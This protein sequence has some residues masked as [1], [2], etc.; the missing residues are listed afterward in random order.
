MTFRLNVAEA[1]RNLT[2]FSSSQLDFKGLSPNAHIA[3]QVAPETRPLYTAYRVGYG[4]PALN[5][6]AL[7]RRAAAIAVTLKDRV[8]SSSTAVQLATF[9]D[10][11]SKQTP[12]LLS[13][14]ILGGAEEYVSNELP[15]AIGGVFA[16]EGGGHALITQDTR[17]M[18]PLDQVVPLNLAFAYEPLLQPGIMK[19]PLSQEWEEMRQN[20]QLWKDNACQAAKW[21]RPIEFNN[22]KNGFTYKGGH[23][24]STVTQNS[25]LRSI[26]SCL[27]ADGYHGYASIR[28][29]RYGVEDKKW[30]SQ[31]GLEFCETDR[32]RLPVLHSWHSRQ[33][34]IADDSGCLLFDPQKPNFLFMAGAV[35]MF[36]GLSLDINNLP[37][38][39]LGSFVTG[40]KAEL[41]GRSN[42]HV[43]YEDP[44]ALYNLN[45]FIPEGKRQ[46]TSL[47]FHF[48]RAH[49]PGAPA[50]LPFEWGIK[51]DNGV[52]IVSVPVTEATAPQTLAWMTRE[53]AVI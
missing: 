12:A 46:L 11:F 16:F 48:D 47:E 51:G 52:S 43:R 38:D 28:E 15:V 41:E 33:S 42:G 36:Q 31:A 24:V 21:G 19:L 1:A 8:G 13:A 26:I 25:S 37:F 17:F 20:Y 45:Q 49:V 9:F 22:I 14:A 29:T 50:D 53:G 2:A 23:S 5:I 35:W 34:E 30:I 44:R 7:R 27:A 32:S 10:Q 6:Q 18:N 3:L 4:D 39:M 40:V